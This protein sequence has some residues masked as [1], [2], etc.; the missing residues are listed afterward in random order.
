MGGSL[1]IVTCHMRK[2]VYKEVSPGNA[3]KPFVHCFWIL[4]VHQAMASI[5]RIVPDGR[6]ELVIHS[7]DPFEKWSP[8]QGLWQK[9]APTLFIGQAREP[10]LLR[11]GLKSEVVGVRFRPAG[12]ERFLKF[13][14]AETTNQIF[15]LTELPLTSAKELTEQVSCCRSSEE[16]LKFVKKFLENRLLDSSPDLLLHH[17]IRFISERYGSIE[18]RDI[19]REFHISERQ[20]ERRFQNGVGLNPKYFARIVRFQS[21]LKAG[22]DRSQWNL[23]DLAM[24][25]GYFD[26]SHFI[27]EFK[28]FS[29]LAPSQYFEERHSISDSF[30]TE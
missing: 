5:E 25:F 19:A 20:I 16:R 8:Q 6:P 28:Q 27:K 22:R 24:R 7:G 29:G 15:D 3:L 26:Q 14:M 2:L 9:Q 4:E 13:C 12:A 17:I 18:L 10:V 23:T 30:T 1:F 21:V 11:T